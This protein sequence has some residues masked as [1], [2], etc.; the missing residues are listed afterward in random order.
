MNAAGAIGDPE[1]LANQD[2]VD[3]LAIR[4]HLVASAPNQLSHD[5]RGD[6]LLDLEH[7][8]VV[9]E[10]RHADNLD[11]RR[12]K[13]A[14]ARQGVAAAGCEMRRAGPGPTRMR[15]ADRTSIAARMTLGARSRTIRYSCS[16][17]INS[18]RY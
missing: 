14:P 1:D 5:L 16:L 11:V 15:V 8:R 17:E 6:L 18:P 3:S 12:Q 2:R 7:R 9:D 13:R 10:H 4:L